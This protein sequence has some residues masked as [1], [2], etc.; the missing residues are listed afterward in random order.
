MT[1]QEIDKLVIETFDLGIHMSKVFSKQEYSPDYMKLAIKACIT[2]LVNGEQSTYSLMPI[3]DYSGE[4]FKNLR[5]GKKI[6]LR[7]TEDATGIS[8]SYLSQFENGKINKPSQ[9]VVNKL[10]NWYHHSIAIPND[11]S[12]FTL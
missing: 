12:P 5:I 9:N 3:N 10:L 4:Y 8:N 7:Q 1:D 2:G 6:T 11:N